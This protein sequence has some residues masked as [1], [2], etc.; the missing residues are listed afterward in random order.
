MPE[1]NH[2]RG[3]LYQILETRAH[4]FEDMRDLKQAGRDYAQAVQYERE[5]GYWRGLTETD[6]PLARVYERVRGE[7]DGD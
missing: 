5:L 7:G 4:I 1:S 6:G 2:L 3:R